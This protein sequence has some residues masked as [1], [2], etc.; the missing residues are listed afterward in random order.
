MLAQTWDDCGGSILEVA[1]D[2]L[3]GAPGTHLFCLSLHALGRW[4]LR[5]RY[6]SP[7]GSRDVPRCPK[8]QAV[9]PGAAVPPADVG[10]GVWS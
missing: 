8:V 10:W 3:G 9:G 1:V 5:E 7:S 2:S 4:G 6:G